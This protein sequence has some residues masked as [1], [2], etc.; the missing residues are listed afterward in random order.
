MQRV[1]KAVT[2]GVESIKAPTQG[3]ARNIISCKFMKQH[4]KGK[5]RAQGNTEWARLVLHCERQRR[6]ERKMTVWMKFLY[7]KL[8]K[9]SGVCKGACVPQAYLAGEAENPQSLHD[10]GV[11]TL[12]LTTTILV[13]QDARV[14]RMLAY[15]AGE[16]E[17]CNR[18]HA[19]E[20][21]GQDGW[22]PKAP[23]LLPQ[24]ARHV[25]PVHGCIGRTKGREA[26]MYSVDRK[27]PETKK[28]KKERASL[29]PTGC[30]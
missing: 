21:E 14:T 28:E 20:H 5:R 13:E 30:H 11:L 2:R 17:D 22:E 4:R 12:L 24:T 23:H 8:S 1:L 18:L 16:A 3:A 15:L 9:V 27:N 6:R 29:W 26:R 10:R 25:S 7:N 19:G